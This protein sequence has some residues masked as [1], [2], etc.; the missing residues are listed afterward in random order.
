MRMLRIFLQSLILVL[1]VPVFFL[2]LK[3]KS[4]DLHALIALPG[5]FI[6]LLLLTLLLREHTE[7]RLK[8]HRE[9]S[10]KVL[11][12]FITF[13][14][15]GMVW[16]SWLIASGQYNSDSRR[17]QLLLNSIEVIGPW[18]PAS[19]FLVMGVVMVWLGYRAW[20]GR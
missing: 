7:S 2:F 18:L 15:S 16:L 9:I 10:M 20:Q 4:F 12:A 13:W 6:L 11:G 14:G 19:V 17:G 8:P 5:V 1:F 3:E